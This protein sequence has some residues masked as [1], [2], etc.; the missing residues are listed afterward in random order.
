M[1]TIVC[2]AFLIH[3]ENIEYDGYR[4]NACPPRSWRAGQQEFE[5]R[6]HDRA[7]VQYTLRFIVSWPCSLIYRS[8]IAP[9]AN[10]AKGTMIRRACSF[11]AELRAELCENFRSLLASEMYPVLPSS[12]ILEL[13]LPDLPEEAVFFDGFEGLEGSE[14]FD[15]S[16]GLEGSEGFDG[17]EGF[18]GSSLGGATQAFSEGAIQA[19]S[20]EGATQASSSLGADQPSSLAGAVQAGVVS[21]SS[22]A[23]DPP[24]LP[25]LPLPDPPDLPDFPEEVEDDSSSAAGAQPSSDQPLGVSSSS[26]LLEDP[27]L[28]P[29]LPLPDPPL[30]PDFP[31]PP[32]DFPEEVESSSLSAGAAQ[33]SAAQGSSS[34]LPAPCHPLLEVTTP[35]SHRHLQ[36]RRLGIRHSCQTSRRNLRTCQTCQRR[37]SHHHHPRMRP[38]YHRGQLRATRC[39]R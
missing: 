28:L 1:D 6:H 36:R 13:L 20:L 32:P 2:G 3:I 25:D 29:D 8:R 23:D 39:W 31:E 9:P 27:P 33:P 19:S 15:G 21:S 7:S 18:D 17:F 30:L 34:W 14:G 37:W 12:S 26:V 24:L 22:S 5:V 4:W 38:M 35:S 10:A 11:W 16:E